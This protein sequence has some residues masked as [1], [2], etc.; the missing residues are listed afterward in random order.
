MSGARAEC[1]WG[2]GPDVLVL[3]ERGGDWPW[4]S[5]QGSFGLTAAEALALAAWLVQAAVEATRLDAGYA[6]AGRPK[7]APP[8]RVAVDFAPCTCELVLGPFRPTCGVD[9]VTAIGGRHY[10]AEHADLVERRRDE[11][12]QRVTV[13]AAGRIL[14]EV[15]MTAQEAPKPSYREDAFYKVRV[16]RPDG[17]WTGPHVMVWSSALGGWVEQYSDFEK[18]KIISPLN[19]QVI[20]TASPMFDE[21]GRAKVHP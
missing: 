13:A 20:D 9:A 5:H 8:F 11:G 16:K 6:E 15:T 12:A 1:T 3:I 21:T 7:T 18:R 10:C 19:V 2:T 14:E 17:T 4:M